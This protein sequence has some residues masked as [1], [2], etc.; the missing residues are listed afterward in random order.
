M[1]RPCVR[2]PKSADTSFPSTDRSS[3]ARSSGRRLRLLNSLFLI[4]EAAGARPAL[5]GRRANEISVTVN[6]ITLDLLLADDWEIKHGHN[7][8]PL[9]L[10]GGGAPLT[11]AILDGGCVKR[12]HR[13]WRDVNGKKLETWLPIIAAE[14]FVHA[15]ERY[16]EKLGKDD[17]HREDRRLA[18]AREA[19]LRA[20]EAE[21]QRRA[22][23]EAAERERVARLLTEARAHHDAQLV[24]AYVDH[25]RANSPGQDRAAFEQWADWAVSVADGRLENV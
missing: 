11:L 7:A 25:L 9:D 14:L 21:R 1:T 4:C 24:R 20:Q 12:W 3:R 16:R 2:K 10:P 6:H 19:A 5:K 13:S 15:D 22:Q 23:A 18:H 8:Y 17:L